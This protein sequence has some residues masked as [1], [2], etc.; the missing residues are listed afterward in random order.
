MPVERAQ[1]ANS[2][3]GTGFASR[4]AV[5]GPFLP[6]RCSRRQGDTKRILYRFRWE[7]G[8]AYEVCVEDYH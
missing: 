3:T 6:S 7:S 4:E 8:D 5:R 2:E 1:R